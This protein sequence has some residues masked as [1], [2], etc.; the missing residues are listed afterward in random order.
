VLS[1]AAEIT[2]EGQVYIREDL[3]FKGTRLKQAT[4]KKELS[5][6][7]AL[8]VS[9]GG[10]GGIGAILLQVFSSFDLRL[11]AGYGTGAKEKSRRRQQGNRKLSRPNM[12]RS[13]RHRRRA[14][15]FP[16]SVGKTCL[17]RGGGSSVFLSSGGRR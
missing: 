1:V 8:K 14:Y 9:E 12:F 13:K 6:K 5:E 11:S 15:G 7:T 4:G 16:R 2:E 10:G 3:Q 17:A